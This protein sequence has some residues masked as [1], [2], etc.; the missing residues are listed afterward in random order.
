MEPPGLRTLDGGLKPTAVTIN[1]SDAS[2]GPQ[3]KRPRS[4][5][6]ARDVPT[7]D[8][9]MN[10]RRLSLIMITSFL[11]GGLA[12]CQQTESPVARTV[13][14]AETT[15]T[16]NPPDINVT[17]PAPAPEPAAKSE[18]STVTVTTPDDPSMSG[19]TTSSSTTTEKK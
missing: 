8:S 7:E 1:H 9:L 16:V 5:S 11:A 14:P 4:V 2:L 3:P 12:A 10:L 17:S 15:V 13:E 6:V 18:S 19:S